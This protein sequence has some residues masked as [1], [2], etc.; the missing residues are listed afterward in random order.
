VCFFLSYFF[1]SY[2]NRKRIGK[3]VRAGRAVGVASREEGQPPGMRLLQLRTACSSPQAPPEATGK[4][5]E[6]ENENGAAETVPPSNSLQSEE[7][8]A[9]EYLRTFALLPVVNRSVNTHLLLLLP[10]QQLLH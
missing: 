2:T 9:S 7:E 1:G 5:S 10:Q 6:T 4:A 8:A 3:M